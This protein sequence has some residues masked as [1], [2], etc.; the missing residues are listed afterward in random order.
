MMDNVS[1]QT[2]GLPSLFRLLNSGR[3]YRCTHPILVTALNLKLEVA[4]DAMYYYDKNFAQHE[5][6]K[7]HAEFYTKCQP[8][9]DR[10]RTQSE[11]GNPERS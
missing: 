2:P 7:Q 3:L 8:M 4:A 9:W 10:Y 11:A 6:G 5:A 1:D